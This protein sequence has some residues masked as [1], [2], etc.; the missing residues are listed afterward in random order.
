MG[1]GMEGAAGS[2]VHV[3]DLLEAQGELT[4]RL[5]VKVIYSCLYT[6]V[7]IG[8]L[9]GNGLLIQNIVKRRSYSVPN[10]FLMNLAVSDLL[11]CMT[12]VPVTPVLAFLKKWLFGRLM[13]K[14]VPLSQAT[15]VLLSSYSLSFIALD[16]QVPIIYYF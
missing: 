13:C 2:C 7:F 16:R 4:L 14:L 11:L 15:S 8:G 1:S 3:N 9:L 10:V 5:D 12:S 6:F